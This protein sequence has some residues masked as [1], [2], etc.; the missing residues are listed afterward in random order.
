MDK[1]D[2]KSLFRQAAMVSGANVPAPA[3]LVAP[4]EVLEKA[5]E[6][7]EDNMTD[8]WEKVKEA[9]EGRF[10]E[11]FI[12]EMDGLSGRE[13]IR[14]YGKMIE[15]FKPKIVRIEGDKEQREENVI[16][17]EIHHSNPQIEQTIDIETEEE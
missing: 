8:K 12:N 17:I 5:T 4:P 2:L 10:A 13:F 6:I 9:M 7:A 14:V 3:H 15:Y 1:E 11:R 16:R